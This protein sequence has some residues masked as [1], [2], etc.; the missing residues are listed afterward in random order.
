M[1]SLVLEHGRTYDQ[2]AACL[3][4][5]QN[6]LR[7]RTR[8][9]ADRLVA[10][11]APPRIDDRQHIVDYLLWQ[12]S[13]LERVQTCSAL[14]DSPLQR[15]WAM[16]LACALAPLSEV[17]LPAIPGSNLPVWQPQA[18]EVVEA[19]PTVRLQRRYAAVGLLLLAMIARA[20]RRHYATAAARSGTELERALTTR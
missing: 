13:H 19:H 12:Q 11:D 6:V 18:G 8:A 20:L 15:E 4:T 5:D 1:L 16:D 3:H 10:C 17:P 14:A 7:Q 2:L 9:A